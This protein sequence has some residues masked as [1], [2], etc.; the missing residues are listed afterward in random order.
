MSYEPDSSLINHALLRTGASRHDCN[1]RASLPP[2]LPLDVKPLDSRREKTMISR[3]VFALAGVV[4][5]GLTVARADDIGWH[6]V[7]VVKFTDFDDVQVKLDG[8][9]TK[10]FF[11][12]LRPIR[13]TVKDEE[14][15]SRLRTEITAKLRKNAL[16]ARILTKKDAPVVGLSVDAFTHHK[17]DF[18]HPWDPND[19]PYCWSGWGAYNLNTYFLWTK[20]TTFVDRLGDSEDYRYY[21]EHLREAVK[22]IE[23]KEKE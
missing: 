2:S 4:L 23:A 15:L 21:R 6:G 8:K 11:A 20:T 13:E 1:R 16:S 3:S 9:E 22:K 12:G 19:H 17:N 10:A 14:K 5:F 18:D 7:E